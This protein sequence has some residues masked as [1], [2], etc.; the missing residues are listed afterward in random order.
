MHP[1]SGGRP[2]MTSGR[3]CAE[4]GCY[5]CHVWLVYLSLR[6]SFS[7]CHTSVRPTYPRRP[8]QLLPL[9]STFSATHQDFPQ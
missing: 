5:I 3:N 2:K 1:R 9:I 8:T 6:L 7:R 4:E